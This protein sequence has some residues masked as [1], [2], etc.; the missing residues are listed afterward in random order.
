MSLRDAVYFS[1]T[2]LQWPQPELQKDTQCAY[3]TP[4]VAVEV[5][6]WC[7]THDEYDDKERETDHDSFDDAPQFYGLV[8]AVLLAILLGCSTTNHTRKPLSFSL[9]QQVHMWT[10]NKETLSFSLT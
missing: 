8:L 3:F 2:T 6:T 7:A 5:L 9:T 4:D 1:L 10:K